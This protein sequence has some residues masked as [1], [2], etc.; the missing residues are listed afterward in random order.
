M[1]DFNLHP[2]FCFKMRIK[3]KESRIRYEFAFLNLHCWLLKFFLTAG[4][5][6]KV[7]QMY[8]LEI[9]SHLWLKNRR[10]YSFWSVSFHKPHRINRNIVHQ[11][12][13]Y[14]LFVCV[15]LLTRKFRKSIEA[16]VFVIDPNKHWLTPR[17][18]HAFHTQPK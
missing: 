3:L 7:C 8:V 12:N 15:F 2:L 11:N 13:I 18:H 10:G 5:L 9:Y 4:Q 16:R 6:L 17:Q 14:L 1:R